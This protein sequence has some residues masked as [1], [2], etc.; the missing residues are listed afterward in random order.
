MER[1]ENHLTPEGMEVLAQAFS[2]GRT[3][4]LELLAVLKTGDEALKVCH[5]WDVHYSGQKLV[6]SVSFIDGKNYK[7]E[8]SVKVD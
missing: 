1:Y 4:L 2:H 8:L 5:F 6:A 3:N 7:L